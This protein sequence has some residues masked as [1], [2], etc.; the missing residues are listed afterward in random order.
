MVNG[1]VEQQPVGTSVLSFHFS[2]VKKFEK[3]KAFKSLESMETRPIQLKESQVH[4]GW[5]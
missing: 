4:T 5:F 3:L 1:N 2:D